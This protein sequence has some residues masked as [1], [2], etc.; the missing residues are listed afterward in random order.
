MRKVNAAVGREAAV[1]ARK[2][3]S[4][5]YAI[6]C[7][8]AEEKCILETDRTW[9]AEA[10]GENASIQ[11]RKI[12]VVAHGVNKEAAEANQAQLTTQLRNQPG[13]PI[14][15]LEAKL[16]RSELLHSCART[17]SMP[18]RVRRVSGISLYSCSAPNKPMSWR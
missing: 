8:T 4:G 2:L 17:T 11:K 5:D 12:L 10:F 13:G 1:A 7:K 18:L 6:T 3:P 14:E 15:V 9:T 16:P